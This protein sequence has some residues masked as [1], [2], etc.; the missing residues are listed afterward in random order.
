[1]AVKNKAEIRAY[2]ESKHIKLKDLAKKFNVSYRTLAHWVKVEKWESAK[3]IKDIDM[4]VLNHDLTQHKLSSFMGAKRQEIKEKIAQNLQGI[5]ID[6]TIMDNLLETSTDE[7]L[8]KAMNLNF[9][10]KNI[11][12]SAIIAKDE[13]FRLVSFNKLAGHK[14]DPM[15]IACAEKTARIFETLKVSL[16]G[17]EA[18]Y[19]DKNINNDYEK[20]S[21]DELLKLIN[22]SSTA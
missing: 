13:L 19:T 22:E 1:M 14:P 5:D 11:L 16:Y 2:Y 6:K 3:A 17:K 15:I 18:I 7:L 20:L 21:T 10:N 12:L 4:Q 8:L 9:I